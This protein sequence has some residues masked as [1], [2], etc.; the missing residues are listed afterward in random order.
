[1]VTETELFEYPD[2]TP[3]ELCLGGRMKECNSQKED[4]YSTENAR[5]GFMCFFPHKTREDQLKQHATFEHE[6]QSALRLRVVFSN[7]YCEL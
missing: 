1:M 3:L 2:L 7:A 4:G 6:L 5:S